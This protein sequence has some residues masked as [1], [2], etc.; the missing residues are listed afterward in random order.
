MSQP[1]DLSERAINCFAH[2]LSHLLAELGPK[3]GLQAGRVIL[4]DMTA[5]ELAE[6]LNNNRNHERSTTH[7]SAGSQSAAT[8][9]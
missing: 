6:L 8:A 5:G 1:N 4:E 2:G 3:A 7:S 9:S